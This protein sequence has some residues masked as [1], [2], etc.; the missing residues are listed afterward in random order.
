MTTITISGKFLFKYFMYLV[1]QIL[2]CGKKN[3]NDENI[4]KQF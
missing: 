1:E 2:L 4:G 3:G